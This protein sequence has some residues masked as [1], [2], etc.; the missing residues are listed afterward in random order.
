MAGTDRRAN[1]IITPDL[2]RTKS[3]AMILSAIGRSPW[4]AAMLIEAIPT[5]FSPNNSS[6]SLVPLLLK[7]RHARS[8]L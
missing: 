6:A 7:S 3:S 1:T 4:I 8:G 5:S 2:C